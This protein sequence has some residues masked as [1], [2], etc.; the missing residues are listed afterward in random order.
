M[1]K[2]KEDS[3]QITERGKTRVFR[4][5]PWVTP[6]DYVDMMVE[7]QAGVIFHGTRYVP[8]MMTREAKD[9]LLRLRL[10]SG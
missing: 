10:I 9:Q 7:A 5:L 3:F 1:V 2:R 8:D 6:E 4:L